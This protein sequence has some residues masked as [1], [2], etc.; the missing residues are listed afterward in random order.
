MHRDTPFSDAGRKLGSPE[1][2]LNT[3]DGHGR[4]GS[5]SEIVSSSQSWKNEFGISMRYPVAPEMKFPPKTGQ[6]A[7]VYL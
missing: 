2:S 3:V 1:S 6:G 7:K 5:R 4:L